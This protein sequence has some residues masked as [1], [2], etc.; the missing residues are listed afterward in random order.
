M[1]QVRHLEAELEQLRT[2]YTAANDT[3]NT[4]QGE[5]YQAGAD[6][7]RIEQSIQH[8]HDIKRRQ[9]E[10][11]QQANLTRKTVIRCKTLQP[12]LLSWNR[13]KPS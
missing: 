10:A 3:F 7:A 2:L 12:Y 5:Y 4:V 6:I 1:A 9:Q 13:V 11:L 8:Q